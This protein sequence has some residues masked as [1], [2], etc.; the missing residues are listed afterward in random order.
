MA[1]EVKKAVFE[2]GDLIFIAVGAG[3]GYLG[4]PIGAVVGALAGYETSRRFKGKEHS[5]P[6]SKYSEGKYHRS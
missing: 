3:L 4:G 5:S 6:S 1:E 2:F